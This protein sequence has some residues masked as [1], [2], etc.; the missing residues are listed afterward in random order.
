LIDVNE[1]TSVSL[2]A[3]DGSEVTITMVKDGR[4]QFVIS[5]YIDD[6]LNV[7]HLHIPR[8]VFDQF[9]SEMRTMQ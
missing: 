4:G 1:C 9:I 5:L 6:G 7:S 8:T 3:E 2:V